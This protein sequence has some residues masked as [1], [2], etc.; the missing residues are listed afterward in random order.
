M[1]R[2]S[3]F[4]VA[5]LLL[6]A[7][8]WPKARAE[9]D[10]IEKIV[11]DG[12]VRISAAAVM[13][14]LSIKEGDPYDE[15]ALRRE[16]GRLWELNLF[17]NIT[18]EVRQGEKGKI[19]LWHVSDKPLIGD[20]EYENLKAFTTTQIEEKLQDQK[21]DIKRGAPMD[22][23]R[24]R[25]AQE[26]LVMLLQQ[27]GYLDAEVRVDVKEIAP[28]QQSI[29]FKARQGGKTKIR[30]IDFTGNTVFKD[31]QLRKMMKLTRQRGFFTWASSKDLY[32]PGKFDEDARLIRQAYLNRGYL[33]VE[34]KPEVV[35]ALPGTRRGTSP[36]REAKALRK[37]QE[38]EAKAI[39]KKARRQERE[40]KK[41][42][43]AEAQ[44]RERAGKG[45]P[46][47][48]PKTAK[49][50]SREP[51]TPKKWIFVSVPIQEGPQYRVGTLSS[52]G[53][54]VYT[55]Q[56][57]LQRVPLSTGQVLNDS[58]VKAGLAR[59]QLDYG[60]KGYF[61]VTA[62]QVVDKTADHVANL[63]IEINEDKQY[64]VN[65]IEFSGNTTT[66]DKVL[67][68]EMRLAE[69]DLFDLKRFRLGLRKIAQ[70]GYW[71]ISDDPAIRPRT[72]E[73][74]VDVV[75]EGKEQS[76][77][78]V[79][80]GGGVSGLDGAFFSGSYATRNFLGRGE[81]LQAYLQIG[82]RASRHSIS[83]I[84]PWFLE[85]PYT[86]GFSLFKR[87]TD[88]AGSQ[89]AG[90]GGSIQVGRL[91]G[92]F[93]RFDVTY[94]LEKVD[95][96]QRGLPDTNN[97]TSS[98]APVFTYDTRN[99]FFRP[100][101]GFRFQI[102]TEYAGGALGGDTYFIKPIAQATLYLPSFGKTYIGLNGEA[103][104]V[105]GLG[106]RVVPPYERF[107]LGGERSLR[108]FQS[109]SV[110]P[111]RNDVDLNG[112]GRIDAPE[113]RDGDGVLDVNED[114]NQN[115]ILDTEDLNHNGVL[116][117][118]ED[119]NN[120][121]LLDT[122]DLDGDGRLDGDEDLNGNGA[123][124]KG[125]DT[126]GDGILGRNDVVG[127]NKFAQFNVEYIVP[128]GDTFELVGFL[129]SGN[130]F[131]DNQQIDLQHFRTDYGVELRFYLPVFQAP[132]RFI[133][134]IIPNPGRG[135]KGNSFQFSIGT[136]F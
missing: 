43:E 6:V 108:A 99:S 2:G 11:V 38:V 116:D 121:G 47:K 88:F 77:N 68:R 76:R 9:G 7:T 64:H 86:V 51:K 20:V 78:E 37:A 66:R 110:A 85:R 95:F 41:K 49:G 130:A 132:L 48:E 124:D 63:K 65:T 115:G 79:Q 22:Y 111:V 33:D 70:L 91:L 114:T 14:Q 34:V 89:R 53:N 39:A 105:R 122:E 35:E 61:Y 23:T 42:A 58:V 133:Y 19:V 128:L 74:K 119:V 52:E 134:G 129:D 55:E 71:Q 50:K 67:R 15:D 94:V 80:V 16:F 103:G 27:K 40:E 28:G 10:M 125:E 82:G 45:K 127:G 113:D 106:S 87:S 90:Q 100:T 8:P 1:R 118:G 75:V 46:P 3:S 135:E 26:T 30:K 123:L 56:E 92:D 84:E 83:F 59:I 107:F 126:N 97:R 102:S 81:I 104:Y 96:H 44:A 21:A 25:K 101:R 72:G 36:Q 109:R 24:I 12:N 136:T 4:I 112:N 60:E 93:S 62:N 54:K 5:T 29:T 13:T 18:L 98:I 17:D 32:H 117:P 57:I 73:S 69:E 120:N 31:R 131:D